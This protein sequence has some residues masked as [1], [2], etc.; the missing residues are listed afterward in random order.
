MKPVGVRRETG[1]GKIFWRLI[2]RYKILFLVLILTV[3]SWAQTATQSTTPDPQQNSSPAAKAKCPCCAKMVAGKMKCANQAMQAMNGKDAETM[4]GSKDGMSCMRNKP[5][6]AASCC[7]KDCEMD[8]CGKS[9]CSK[10]KTSCCGDRCNK[11]GQNCCAGK[12]SEKTAKSCCH[13]ELRG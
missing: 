11:N 8:K 13:G 3:M 1:T 9:S 2:M 7:G 4:S 12:T 10:D 5:E 6:T